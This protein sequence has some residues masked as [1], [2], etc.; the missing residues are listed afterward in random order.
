M[1]IFAYAFGKAHYPHVDRARDAEVA[2]GESSDVP[3]FRT[4]ARLVRLSHPH[5]VELHVDCST[6]IAKA[7]CIMSGAFLRSASDMWVTIDDD[8][9]ADEPSL[10]A[11]L[12]SF[13]R[14]EMKTDVEHAAAM[15]FAAMKTR[16]NDKYNVGML[17]ANDRADDDGM[18]NMKAGEL[19]LIGHGGPALAAI[20]RAPLEAMAARFDAVEWDDDQGYPTPG[21][22]AEGI[23]NRKWVGEDVMFCKRARASGVRLYSFFHPGITHAG[24][25]SVRP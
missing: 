14:P 25:P 13:E 3:A 15:V 24:I 18:L 10:R 12:S 23:V 19:F 9:D 16:T 6:L 1:S 11:L 7:R 22:F 4:L 8:V 17:D 2:K 5:G 21:L 20:P